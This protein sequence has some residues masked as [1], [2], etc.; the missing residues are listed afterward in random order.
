[1]A[2]NDSFYRRAERQIEYVTLGMGVVGALFAAARWGWRCAAG[3]MLG[4]FLAW[5]NYRWLK[6]GMDAL[7]QLSLAQAESEKVR[8][9]KRVYVKFFARY[10]LIIAV[11]Y[12]ILRGSLV[13]AAA[14]LAGLFALVGAVLV[15]MISLL[16]RG[17]G[18]TS[19]L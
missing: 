10:A 15:V 6:Q 3:V 4:A 9:P 7:T 11:V 13:P 19:A 14:V 1:M 8:I 5:I 2:A 12:A 16:L 17:P 18:E